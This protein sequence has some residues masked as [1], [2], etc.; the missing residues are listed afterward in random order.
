[1]ALILL[2]RRQGRHL[3]L[4][5]VMAFLWFDS[6]LF[7]TSIPHLFSLKTIRKNVALPDGVHGGRHRGNDCG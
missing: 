6:G 7:S 2:I 5:A 4:A 3:S 1:M